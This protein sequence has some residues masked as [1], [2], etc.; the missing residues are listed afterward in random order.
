MLGV[1]AAAL[2]F[3]APHAALT[4]CNQ[5]HQHGSRSTLMLEAPEVALVG[6][7][8]VAV[9][10]LVWP[11]KAA[12][13]TANEASSDRKIQD[14]IR[15]AS[16][17]GATAYRE[18]QSP[19]AEALSPEAEAE[20]QERRRA[21]EARAYAMIDTM[22][23]DAQSGLDEA[24]RDNDEETAAEYQELL[25]QLSPLPPGIVPTSKP[26]DYKRWID[27]NSLKG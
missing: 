21:V 10:L 20:R 1:V 11:N 3:S 27:P 17:T 24:M 8:A 7:C 6:G 25:D 19:P 18:I 4:P 22:R 12:A 2:S 15:Q 26:A 5:R 13:P 16:A 9:A 14:R 23:S